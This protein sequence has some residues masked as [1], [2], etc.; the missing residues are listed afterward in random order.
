MWDARHFS[1]AEKGSHEEVL[2]A[3]TERALLGLGH[4]ELG[5][6]HG[7]ERKGNLGYDRQSGVQV[8]EELRP[9]D[10]RGRRGIEHEVVVLDRVPQ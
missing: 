6:A 2:A 8:A 7:V 9:E 5:G 3:M 4:D 1:N 10:Q